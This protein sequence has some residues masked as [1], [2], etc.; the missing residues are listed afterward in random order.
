M[1]GMP[2][3]TFDE[4][5]Q[6]AISEM[7]N[8]LTATAATNLTA[9]GKEVDISTPSLSVGEDFQIKI[10]PG[11]FLVVTMDIGGH[12]VEINIAVE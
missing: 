3:E 11:Q 12:V 6:S 5:A 10:A 2:V 1:M 4:M 7:S 8:M 9:L